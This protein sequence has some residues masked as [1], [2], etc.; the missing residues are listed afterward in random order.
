MV[1]VRVFCLKR[2]TAEPLAVPFRV[3]C[4]ENQNLNHKFFSLGVLWVLCAFRQERKKER[5][6]I[7]TLRCEGIH[8]GFL[9]MSVDLIEKIVQAN[10]TVFN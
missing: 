4:Q 5:E 6:V 9:E 10:R 2:C 1:L 8:P 7:A 3:S